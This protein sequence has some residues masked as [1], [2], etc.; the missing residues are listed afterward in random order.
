MI[1]AFALAITGAVIL[2]YRAGY[3]SGTRRSGHT[4]ALDQGGTPP[5][6]AFELGDDPLAQDSAASRHLTWEPGITLKVKF[7]D[8]SPAKWEKVKRYAMEWTR[9]ANI[10]FAFFT[11][12]DPTPPGPTIRISFQRQGHWSLIGS[13][14]AHR[15]PAVPTMNLNYRLFN[16]SD[17]EIRRVVLHEF[18][19]ALGLW[20]EHQNPTIAFRW[21]KQEVYEHYRRRY[22]WSRSKVDANIFRKLD[23]ARVNA[24]AFDPASIML[25]A[26]PSRF[27]LDGVVLRLNWDLSQ[28]DK[29][30]IARLYPGRWAEQPTTATAQAPTKAADKA[31][32]V[33]ARSADK[34][35]PAA[36]NTTPVPA[37][38]ASRTSP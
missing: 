16:K 6:A 1:V 10:N 33:G 11:P 13:Q 37:A 21:N 24:T 26:F 20:H 17:R 30:Q 38:P 32:R 31:A 7:M 14:A 29:R 12:S 27:T 9:Y 23:K 2:S 36:A 34:A 35:A 15:N 3:A 18:G 22:G 5:C 25:Y 4:G 8:G 19:H 28:T